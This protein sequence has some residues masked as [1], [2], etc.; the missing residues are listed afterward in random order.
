VDIATVFLE[1]HDTLRG[2]MRRLAAAPVEEWRPRPHGVNSLA[3][4]VWHMA[5]VE[6]AGVNRLVFEEPQV[7]DDP[8]ARWTERMNIPWRHHGTTMTEAE[9]DELTARAD[10]PALWAYYSAVTDR[11]RGLVAAGLRDEVLDPPVEP[12]RLRR[13]LFDEGVLRPDY[14]WNRES[15]PYADRARGCLLFHFAITHNYSHWNDVSA[16][17]GFLGALAG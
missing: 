16:L 7:L 1:R 5:R 12:A 3:W 4:L 13:V 6:D 14:A 2:W 17:R 15:P 11:T 10:V 9:V 8:G